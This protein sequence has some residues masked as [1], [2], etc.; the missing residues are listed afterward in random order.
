M[1]E[2]VV[3]VHGIWMTG[4]EMLLLR[5]RL[6]QCGYEC[7]NYRYQSMRRSPRENATHLNHYLQGIEAEVV[8]L[9]AH[10]LGGIVLLHLFDQYPWQKPGR[11]VMLGTPIRGSQAAQ[12]MVSSRWLQHL[13]GRSVERG[14]LGDAPRWQSDREL[15]MIAGTEG[16]GI[17][18]LITLGKLQQPNDGTVRLA[19]TC[20]SGI[21]EHLALPY[22]H[23]GMI[24]AKPVA[25][26][27]C[28]FL[29]AGRFN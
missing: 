2:A 4:A 16:F 25:N 3:L 21:K 15:G 29:Q 18:K 23:T 24:F 1:R 27:V 14:L 28:R 7:Y 10:S 8:H 13:L 17:G 9:V 11:V 6:G 5:R 12:K 22:S 20:S 26:A 19:A